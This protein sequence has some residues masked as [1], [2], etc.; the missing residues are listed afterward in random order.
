MVEFNPTACT[1]LLGALP[2]LNRGSA[3]HDKFLG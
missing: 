3:G 1:R 2:W